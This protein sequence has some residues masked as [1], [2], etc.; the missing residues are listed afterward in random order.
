MRLFMFSWKNRQIDFLN[1]KEIEFASSICIGITQKA[2][3]NENRTKKTS[4]SMGN[5]TVFAAFIRRSSL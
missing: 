3:T 5:S 2:T 1:R 4:N